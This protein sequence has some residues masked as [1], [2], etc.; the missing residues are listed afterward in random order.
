VLHVSHGVGFGVGLAYY[1]LVQRDWTAPPEHLVSITAA[2]RS[3]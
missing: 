1:G 2:Q 3:S